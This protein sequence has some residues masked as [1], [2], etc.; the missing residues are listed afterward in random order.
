M[1]NKVAHFAMFAFITD[2]FAKVAARFVS[3]HFEETLKYASLQFPINNTIGGCAGLV[4]NWP[5]QSLLYVS[6]RNSFRGE[7]TE[8]FFLRHHR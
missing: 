3:G 7:M 2:N 4:A 1:R 8:M 6:R 5:P